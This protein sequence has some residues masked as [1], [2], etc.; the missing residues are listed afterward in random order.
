MFLAE[1]FHEL[2]THLFHRLHYDYPCN[3]I[4]S[5]R[6]AAYRKNLQPVPLVRD[7]V[8]MVRTVLTPKD[9]LLETTTS[10]SGAA[11]VAPLPGAVEPG[12]V[13][14]SQQFG[15]RSSEVLVMRR[16]GTLVHR[17]KVVWS[18]VWSPLEGNF[19][20]RPVGEMYIHGLQILTDGSL[21]ANFEHRSTFRMD[22]CAK[23]FGSSTI[24]GITPFT[25]RLME[26]SGYRRKTLSQRERPDI[27]RT[28]RLCG[29]IRCSR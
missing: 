14:V 16:D 1:E 29:H 9:A 6:G 7:A 20:K 13:V 4:V 10:A 2:G 3:R 12:L 25:P 27:Q 17:W 11:I 24:L 15:R 5:L 22:L 21:V 19:E 18:A 28:I 8:A 26:P 23:S